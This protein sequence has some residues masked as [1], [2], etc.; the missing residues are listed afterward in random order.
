MVFEE[1]IEINFRP[2]EG[3]YVDDS[4]IIFHDGKVIFVDAYIEEFDDIDDN[5][6]WFSGKSLKWRYE[7][8]LENEKSK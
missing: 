6:V 8:E 3:Y 7:L 1:N 2:C 4:A 5:M